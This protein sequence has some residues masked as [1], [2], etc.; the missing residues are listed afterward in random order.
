M[1]ES[2]LKE[3]V[4][5][6]HDQFVVEFF[7]QATHIQCDQSRMQKCQSSV[8][9]WLTT[10]AQEHGCTTG[11][12]SVALVDDAFIR[13]VNAKHLQHDWP[14]DV[15][16]FLLDSSDDAISGEL[17]ISVE[18]ALRM[19]HHVPWDA[20][21]E[22]LLYAIHGM[23]HLVGYTDATE[24]EANEM[25]EREREYLVRAGVP[26][27]NGHGSIHWVHN[28]ANDQCELSSREFERTDSPKRCADATENSSK[29]HP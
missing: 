18:T 4:L 27:A 23:L 22:T 20:E 3:S 5:R 25:R 1:D 28:D 13:N 9:K 16:S 26:E 8:R 2:Q 19:S 17:V 29:D 7:V 10:I 12:I 6:S 11:T 14:T 24:T 21:S 15:I